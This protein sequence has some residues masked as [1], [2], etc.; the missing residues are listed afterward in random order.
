MSDGIK[1]QV[2]FCIQILGSLLSQV[3]A[4]FVGTG[5]ARGLD[6]DETVKTGSGI[7]DTEIV[8]T[9]TGFGSGIRPHCTEGPDD[10]GQIHFRK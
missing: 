7:F 8:Q 6:A 9:F 3:K 5:K 1:V 4:Q 10:L 2:F